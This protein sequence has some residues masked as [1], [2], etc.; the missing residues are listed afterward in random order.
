MKTI[1]IGALTALVLAAPLTTVAQTTYEA[2]PVP[3]FDDRWYILPFATYNWVDQN[4]ETEDNW[5]VGL[6][7]GKPLSEH[8]NLELRSTYTDLVSK[9]DIGGDYTVTDVAVD[10][11]FFFNRGKFQPFLLAGIGAIQDSFSCN[12]AQINV[13][14]GCQSGTKW[15]F[16]AEAGAGFLIPINDYVS[17][18]MDGRY[19]YDDNAGNFTT[20]DGLGDWIVTAGV[21]IPLGSR[22][23]APKVTRTYE[24]SADTLFAFNRYDLSPTGVTTINNFSRDL[25]QSNFDS[26]RVAGH[27]DPIG[28]EAYNLAL[29]DRR[30]GTVRDQLVTDGVPADRISAQGYGKS[31]LK[32]TPADCAHTNSRAA[33]IECYQPNRR[34]EVTV[35]GMTA[36]Q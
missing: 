16:M 4:R 23:A 27:T 32:V 20:P 5:G 25:G 35:E 36:K 18:R 19:R 11:L 8:F 10:G 30:A 9:G 12:A 17:F 28:S 3:R 33:L 7:V 14:W 34:V 24:L 2:S 21:V 1:S 6:A 22:A 15:S 13:A 29:S 31:N 26:I